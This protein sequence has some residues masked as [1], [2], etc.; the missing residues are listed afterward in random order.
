MFGRQLSSETH[1]IDGK[2]HG[3]ERSWGVSGKLDRG[4]PRYWVN[5]SRVTKRQYVVA[6]REDRSLPPFHERDNRTKRSLPARV[7]A[8]IERYS[9]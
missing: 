6:A 1:F 4:Y 9:A 7:R 3:I 5:D 2:L 8:E